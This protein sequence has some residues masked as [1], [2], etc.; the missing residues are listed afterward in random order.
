M[1]KRVNQLYTVSKKRLF[2]T[3]C[4][5]LTRPVTLWKAENEHIFIQIYNKSW[6]LEN[7]AI[8]LKFILKILTLVLTQPDRLH[9]VDQL[10]LKLSCDQ[11]FPSNCFEFRGMWN[12]IGKR[13]TKI[14]NKS[15]TVYKSGNYYN[16][17]IIDMLIAKKQWL[18]CWDT[19]YTFSFIILVQTHLRRNSAIVESRGNLKISQQLNHL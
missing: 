8:E 17:L 14:N 5:R 18:S 13:V 6:L 7:D 11:D 15:C 1:P 12:I 16:R 19:V 2:A 4:F 9:A 3:F 10:L